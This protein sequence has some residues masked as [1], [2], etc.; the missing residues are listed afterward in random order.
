MLAPVEMARIIIRE[1]IARQEVLDQKKETFRSLRVSGIPFNI[2]FPENSPA[3]L[4]AQRQ[5]ERKAILNENPKEMMQALY[6]SQADNSMFGVFFRALDLEFRFRKRETDAGTL[7]DQGPSS[8]MRSTETVRQHNLDLLQAVKLF[9]SRYDQARINLNEFFCI[10]LVLFHEADEVVNGD[11]TLDAKDQKG[12]INETMKGEFLYAEEVEI[13]KNVFD[14]LIPSDV[15]QREE[16]VVWWAH[17]VSLFNHPVLLNRTH[18]LALELAVM[19]FFD[20]WQ[21]NEFWLHD[22]QPEMKKLDE[23]TAKKQEEKIRSRFQLYFE[24]MIE[25]GISKDLFHSLVQIWG[26]QAEEFAKLGVNIVLRDKNG[27]DFRIVFKHD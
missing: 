14:K 13:L 19:R 5:T 15:P 1:P 21:G 22:K 12:L 20:T 2:H 9:F 17:T 18:P 6:N 16:S 8:T 24:K 25:L 27:T 10:G 11:T 7:L 4:I 23:V 26:V 3:A